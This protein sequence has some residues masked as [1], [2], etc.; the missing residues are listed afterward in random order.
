M[1]LNHMEWVYVNPEMNIK[2]KLFNFI[3]PTKETVNLHPFSEVNH[4]KQKQNEIDPRLINLI[5]P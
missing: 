5:Q 1:S 4:N 3:G 2:S